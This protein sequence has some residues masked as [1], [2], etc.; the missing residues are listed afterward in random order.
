MPRLS[1]NAGVIG[2]TRT[3]IHPQNC[4]V[5][6]SCAIVASGHPPAA[7]PSRAMSSR[8]LIDFSRSEARAIVIARLS[9]L[10]EALI[11]ARHRERQAIVVLAGIAERPLDRLLDRAR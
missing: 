7:Y 1:A 3:P 4:G 9:V 6:K 8:R 10:E 2:P 11:L 5:A